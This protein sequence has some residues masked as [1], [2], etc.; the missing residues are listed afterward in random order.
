[1]NFEPRECRVDLTCI[2]FRQDHRAHAALSRSVELLD[3]AA[4]R[5]NLSLNRKFAGYSNILA[6]RR[7]GNRRVKR[8]KNC[9]PRRGTVDIS[10]TDDI[11]MQIEI[12]DIDTGLRAQH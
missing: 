11:D 3:H 10:T 4:D 1:M 7:F 5:A 6:D 9:K 2:L 8:K 12:G